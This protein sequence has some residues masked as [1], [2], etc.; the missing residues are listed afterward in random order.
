MAVERMYRENAA[1][2]SRVSVKTGR[3]MS[4][5]SPIIANIEF[6]WLASKPNKC[7]FSENT[8]MRI[9]PRKKT[10]MA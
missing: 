8:W 9:S 7:R 2:V 6:D 4:C 1:I 10:G 5:Q 3:N